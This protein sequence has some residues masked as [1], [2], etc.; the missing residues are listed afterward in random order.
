MDMNFPH[1]GAQEDPQEP[2]LLKFTAGFFSLMGHIGKTDP[3]TAKL[4]LRQIYQQSYGIFDHLGQEKKDESLA[5]EPDQKRPLAS[6]AKHPAESVSVASIYHERY[7]EYRLSNVL[8]Y[9]GVTWSD[10]LNYPHDHCDFL[11][12]YSLRESKRDE[13]S[14][15]QTRQQL[16]NSMNQLGNNH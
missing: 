14:E 1:M 13:Q 2:T 8:K 15:E 5:T 11:I 12:E 9:T 6:I 4:L 10:F 3:V 16:Q 7:T